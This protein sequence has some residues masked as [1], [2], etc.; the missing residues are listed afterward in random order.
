MSWQA[1]DCFVSNIEGLRGGSMEEGMLN[2]LDELLYLYGEHGNGWYLLGTRDTTDYEGC[3][4]DDFDVPQWDRGWSYAWLPNPFMKPG[5]LAMRIRR[6]HDLL[7]AAFECWDSH[8]YAIAYA[9]DGD[10][11]LQHMVI[12]GVEYDM[13]AV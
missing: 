13:R 12:R 6:P 11:P 8:W 9:G 2:A 10:E 4:Q 1:S 3:D 5:L 7:E